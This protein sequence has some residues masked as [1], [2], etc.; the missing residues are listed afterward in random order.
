MQVGGALPIPGAGRPTGKVSGKN[1][2]D[3][4]KGIFDLEPVSIL[5]FT[6]S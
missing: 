6:E 4:R 5:S 1:Y 3:V 2:A